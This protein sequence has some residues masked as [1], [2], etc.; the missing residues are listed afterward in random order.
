MILKV[1]NDYIKK[2]DDLIK[3]K[4]EKTEDYTEADCLFS[5]IIWNYF[6]NNNNERNRSK[7]MIDKYLNGEMKINVHSVKK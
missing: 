1:D 6:T 5:R 3:K 7:I 4:I 2:M